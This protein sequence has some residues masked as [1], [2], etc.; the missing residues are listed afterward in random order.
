MSNLSDFLDSEVVINKL[1]YLTGPKATVIFSTI[2][3]LFTA[4]PNHEW[5]NSNLKGIL[6]FIFDREL[7]KTPFFRLFS[8]ENFELL[9]ECELYYNFNENFIKFND[10][11]YYFEISGGFIGFSYLNQFHA[12]NMK[13]II[14]QF[15]L[16][17]L[18]EKIEK[19]KK[20]TIMKSYSE[21]NARKAR[22]I[23]ENELGFFDKIKIIFDKSSKG[24]QKNY[25]D[26]IIGK[27]TNIQHL[28]SIKVDKLTGDIKT[29]KLPYLW[30]NVLQNYKLTKND[31]KYNNKDN[32]EFDETLKELKKYASQDNM[33]FKNKNIEKNWQKLNKGPQYLSTQNVT[34]KIFRNDTN[35]VYNFGDDSKFNFL[36]IPDHVI[37]FY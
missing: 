8:I 35:S 19:I 29:D 10:F 9:F 26:V 32:S 15:S 21:S 16:K 33:N 31:L 11:F 25:N 34:S 4:N 37:L 20:E 5:I 30:E 1:N 12:E 24:I 18:E 28:A 6:C 3:K 27:P 17:N 13:K 2:V 36:Q 14:E 23:R 22:Q 7:G